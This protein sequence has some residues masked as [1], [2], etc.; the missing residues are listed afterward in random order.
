M[1]IGSKIS[2]VGSALVKQYTAESTTLN[3]KSEMFK[4]MLALM[5]Q[6]QSK[7]SPEDFGCSEE[8]Y[9]VIVATPPE[10]M[11]FKP[12]NAEEFGYP[13]SIFENYVELTLK[14]LG[15][16]IDNKWGNFNEESRKNIC[17]SMYLSFEAVH[18]ILKLRKEIFHSR[19]T[20]TPT[21]N[22]EK[23]RNQFVAFAEKIKK[24][25]TLIENELSNVIDLRKR[26]RRTANFSEKTEG[27]IR[28]DV[29]NIKAYIEN[30]K[31][32]IEKVTFRS[33]A[34]VFKKTAD[35]SR[36][37]ARCSIFAAIVL[38]GIG[39]AWGILLSDQGLRESC[40]DSLFCLLLNIGVRGFFLATG[41][42]IIGIYAS[43][44]S[45]FAHS[46]SEAN[47]RQRFNAL[48]SYEKMLELAPSDEAKN[49]MM[50]KAVECIYSHQSTGF[51]KEQQKDSDS[52]TTFVLPQPSPMQKPDSLP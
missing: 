20:P 19:L 34:M 13:M 15:Y 46:Q 28:Q 30:I 10:I 35:N 41:I 39:L 25:E 22:Q 5:K 4:D 38:G 26:I 33:E 14:E 31:A 8:M 9:N 6:Y 42:L 52:K 45:Y 16:D 43:I 49:M 36:N 23:I 3:K 37:R 7:S 2:D 29:E 44:R 51:V 12:S 50:Q 1:N 24:S 18:E 40:L 17:R 21:I 27:K 11:S 48:V 47:N 32:Y